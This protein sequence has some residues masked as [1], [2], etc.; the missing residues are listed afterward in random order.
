MIGYFS[1]AAISAGSIHSTTTLRRRVPPRRRQLAL[2]SPAGE[3]EDAGEVRGELLD[4]GV[5]TAGSRVVDD[6]GNADVGQ[7][8]PG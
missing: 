7:D 4:G 3:A 8:L 2:V 6:V 5:A 1:N